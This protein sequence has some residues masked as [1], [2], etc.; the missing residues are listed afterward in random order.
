MPHVLGNF[1]ELLLKMP[2]WEQIA[3]NTELVVAFGGLAMKN[4]QVHAGGFGRHIARE[5]QQACV[6][7]GVEFV[8][9]SALR[10]DAAEFLNAAWLCPRPNSDTA[11]MLALAHTLVREGLHNEDFLARCCV[12]WEKFRPYLLGE[13]DGV[14]KDADWAAKISGLPAATIRDLARRMAG[15]RT[16]ITVSWSLQR[17]D[18][19][20]MPYWMSIVL[21]AVLGQIGLP[22]GG[23]GFGYGAVNGMGAGGARIPLPALSQGVN[24]VS[25]FI[26]VARIADMLE[27]PGAAFAYNGRML[28]Y[29]DARMIYWCGGNPFHHHQQIGRLARAWQMPETIIAHEPWWNAHARHADIVLPSTTTV[30]RN[31]IAGTVQDTYALAMQ[32][33]VAPFGQAR[34]DHD[35]FA[36]LAERLGFREAFTEGRDE[37]GWVETLYTRWRDRAAAQNVEMPAFQAFWEAGHFRLPEQPVPVFL[38]DFRAAPD[39]HKL[40]TP[41]GKIEIFSATVAGLGYDDYPGYPVWHEPVE[42]LGNTRAYPLHLISNQPR[43]RLHSQLDNGIVSQTSKVNGREPIWIHPADAAARGIAGG[44]IVRVF[45]GRGACLAGVVVTDG[46]MRGVVQLATGAWYAPL[47]ED[48]AHDQ[49]NSLSFCAAGNP[50][51]LTRDAGTSRLA[52]GPG[53][54]TCLV[55]VEKYT[56]TLPPLTSQEPPVVVP[57]T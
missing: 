6:A 57:R 49:S 38:A 4:T 55:N 26:P 18:H 24:P 44:D 9:L 10:D 14:A 31:D 11:V 56:G 2:T 29:P 3:A 35:I 51:V 22:G 28:N 16:L 32:K 45:N 40:T 33:A 39:V 25:A 52:Q 23:I 1:F 27:N 43:T 46:V 42:W 5:A 13:S 30:E 54:H 15:K 20:E 50:N 12:G 53:A 17:A 21:A 19:G 7:R 8:S 41:S 48:G 47:P 34:N 37:M 36:A